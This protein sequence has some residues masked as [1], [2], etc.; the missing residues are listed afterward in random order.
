MARRLVQ[1][2]RAY[3]QNVCLHEAAEQQVRSVLMMGC[4]DCLQ[5]AGCRDEGVRVRWASARG[6]LGAG[7][8]HTGRGGEGGQKGRKG[9][10]RLHT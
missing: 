4:R 7:V 10:Y 8:M 6:F 2:Q 1:S 5:W 9:K 3:A